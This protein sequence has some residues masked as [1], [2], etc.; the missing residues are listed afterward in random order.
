MPSHGKKRQTKSLEQISR[1]KPDYLQNKED[2][3]EPDMTLQGKNISQRK[4][5]EEVGHIKS[6]LLFM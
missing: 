5:Q 4:Q 2:E 1:V 3:T 6:G